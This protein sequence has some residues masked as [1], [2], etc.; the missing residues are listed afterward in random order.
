MTSSLGRS[1]IHSK[2]KNVAAGKA[3]RDE[4]M[5]QMQILA[6][7]QMRYEENSREKKKL[8][9]IWDT[10]NL[11]EFLMVADN[12]T[13]GYT[14][15]RDVRVVVGGA[16]HV[17]KQNK[18]VP[19]PGDTSR[20]WHGMSSM[21]EIPHRPEWS[22]K[23]RAEELQLKEKSMFVEWRRKLAKLE[24][25]TN[26]TLT[27]YEKNLEVW[28]QLWRVVERSDVVVQ[29]VDARNPLAFRCCDLERVVAS[30]RVS[31]PPSAA[32]AAAAEPPA[33]AA[34]TPAP[35]KQ[36]IMLLN[37]ADLL[38]EDQR[39][40][41]AEYLTQ[42]GVK[43][44]FFCAAP[45]VEE[46]TTES[47][48]DDEEGGATAA[49]EA[50][51]APP[52]L[53][54]KPVHHKR[55]AGENR[56][57]GAPQVVEHP[58]LMQTTKEAAQQKLRD[59]KAP[60]VA[61]PTA[62]EIARDR[63]R[64]ALAAGALAP[65]QPF[66]VIDAQGL[67]DELAA[68]RASLG[69]AETDAV[70]VGMVGYPNVGKS[71]TI[72]ALLNFKQVVVSATPG[73]TKHFQT[74]TIPDER[75]VMLCD[76]PGLVF[77]S[78]A[79]TRESMVV[80]GIL[81]VDT[82]KDYTTPIGLICRR[83]PGTVMEL[84][85]RVQLDP[86]LDVDESCSVADLLLNAIARR[87]GYMT[88]HNKPNRSKVAKEMLKDYVDGRLIYV[89]PPPGLVLT[90]PSAPTTAPSQP[91][92][93]G[94]DDDGGDGDDDDDGGDEEDDLE[95]VYSAED[96]R[97]L[98]DAGGDDAD[99]DAEELADPRRF[100]D[101]P[102]GGPS[103]PT[104][105]YVDPAV[106]R[107]LST[108]ELFNSVQ[109]TEY[110]EAALAAL[111]SKAPIFKKKR[112][113]QLEPDQFVAVSAAGETELL[114]DS[115]DDIVATGGGEDADAFVSQAAPSRQ[116]QPSKRQARR[117]MKQARGVPAA[118]NGSAPPPRKRIMS[119]RLPAAP[120]CRASRS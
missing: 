23:M 116:R 38:H 19:L 3:R 31:R 35:A 43:F 60:K 25:T 68:M 112:N 52:L 48:S 63:R 14:A 103:K 105:R 118:T 104:G 13:E 7:E 73:K 90:D 70:M 36:L 17:V 16:A 41:W 115:D 106:A 83:V 94:D 96:A 55:R 107:P 11:D 54:T 1:L 57:R 44:Y 99:A 119:A 71:S 32:A 10:S 9:S 101:R 18:V 58:H 76:C 26:V 66:D 62:A 15:A 20:D 12:R 5:L 6:D 80:D 95:D 75:R 39:R 89:H 29:I 22:F 114:I 72:N 40:A 34:A 67:L 53:A 93:H 50:S 33:A 69:V 86:S 84:R 49:L 28:R 42:L 64:L 78:F 27:P 109:N 102:V 110:C 111:E 82:V 47:S 77:P 8:K 98:S 2:Q 92:A 37:K 45:K 21:L 87:R 91:R 56:L 88:D 85:Y 74:L 59:R 113:P 79:A 108:A 24:E 51:P 61:E 46:P 81:P 4:K 100:L 120:S 65:R 117:M 30:Q 97:G